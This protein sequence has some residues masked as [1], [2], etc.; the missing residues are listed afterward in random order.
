[1]AVGTGPA[2]ASS[3]T[4]G[5]LITFSEPEGPLGRGQEV[6]VTLQ[7]PSG[8]NLTQLFEFRS[9]FLKIVDDRGLEQARMDLTS[10][11]AYDNGS[12]S[13]GSVSFIVPDLEASEYRF[14][15]SAT[16]NYNNRSQ[17]SVMYAVGNVS[18]R[19][20]VT[21]VRA[22]PNPFDP[23]GEPLR[24]LFT[25]SRS[26]E[27]TVRIYTVSG[28]LVRRE[29]LAGTRGENAF[30]WD[31]RDGRGDPVANGVYLVLLS[32]GDADPQRHLER[33]VVLR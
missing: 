12:S 21:G 2:A 26:S 9:V 19:S 7:D 25:L 11:F 16:D 31:G 20:D 8:I 18:T 32:T 24:L 6:T 22:Y 30:G 17:T 3:D 33:L 5:P 29:S 4:T 27:V 10:G 1:M 14:T 13:R 28:R 23:E 15:V